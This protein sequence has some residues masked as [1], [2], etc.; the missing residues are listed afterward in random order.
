MKFKFSDILTW[1]FDWFGLRGKQTKYRPHFYS[2]NAWSYVGNGKMTP[3]IELM[4][5]LCS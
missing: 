1:V 3:A 5:R 4:L 2:K